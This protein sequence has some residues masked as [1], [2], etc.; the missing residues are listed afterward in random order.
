MILQYF[1]HSQDVVDPNFQTRMAACFDLAAYIPKDEKVKV[2]EGKETSE[3][4]PQ[5]DHDKNQYYILLMPGE[6]ALVRTGLTFDIPSGYSIR[7]HP[8]SGMAL[9]Y[10]LTLANCEGVVDEDYTYETKLIMINTNLQ[11][12]IKIYNGDRIAQ[13]E[14]VNYEQVGF[15][16]IYNQPGL[17]TDRVGGFGSTGVN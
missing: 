5:Y 17:K 12:P 14:V 3:I 13:A 2:W 1:K 8:R 7:L 15:M 11:E 9:K 16:E 4:E 6:R 10:G